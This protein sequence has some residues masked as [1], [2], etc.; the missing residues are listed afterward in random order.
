[1]RTAGLDPKYAAGGGTPRLDPT[2]AD[3][4]FWI[5]RARVFQ[6]NVPALGPDDF[7]TVDSSINDLPVGVGPRPKKPRP[8]PTPP[9]PDAD[10]APRGNYC[11]RQG[12]CTVGCL[13]GA[14][15]TLN[16]QLMQAMYGGIAC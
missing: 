13:P 1:V 6:A 11:Q 14:R 10:G 12:R 2:Q 8:F 9:E 4:N 3:N 16:K 15:H 5:D 7:G